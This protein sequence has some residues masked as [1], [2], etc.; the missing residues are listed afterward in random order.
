MSQYTVVSANSIATLSEKVEKLMQEGWKV[1]GGVS[2]SQDDCCT[3]Y[4]QALVKD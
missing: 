3:C 2:M 4:C 1:A